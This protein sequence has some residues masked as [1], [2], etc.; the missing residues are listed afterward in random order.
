VGL[1]QVD[2]P[3]DGRDEKGL[4]E[5]VQPVDASRP[6]QQLDGGSRGAGPDG[7]EGDERLPPGEGGVHGRQVGDEEGQ[8]HEPQRRLGEGDDGD[9]SALRAHE[10]QGQQRRAA[11]ADGVAEAGDAEAD[12]HRRVADE[13]HRQP[14][15]GQGYQ[16]QGGVEGHGPVPGLVGLGE[17][18]SPLEEGPQRPEDQPGQPDGKAPGNDHGDHGGQEGERHYHRPAKEE[19]GPEGDGHGA[20]W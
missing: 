20:R 8:Q 13:H 9:P 1:L 3:V 14:H 16:G 4:L 6:L 19:E 7:D 11:G 5:V 2:E 10:T 18:P 17:A 12:I 15:Q